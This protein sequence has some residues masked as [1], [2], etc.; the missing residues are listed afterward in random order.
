[1]HKTARIS[2]LSPEQA[3]EELEDYVMSGKSD[4]RDVK[5]N[6]VSRVVSTGQYRV[7]LHESVLLLR[8][9]MIIVSF[10]TGTG[11]AGAFTVERQAEGCRDICSKRG[12]GTRS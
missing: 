12:C 2:A 11:G 7:R 5:Y 9:P 4:E 6:G 3:D 10:L 1:M 8:R